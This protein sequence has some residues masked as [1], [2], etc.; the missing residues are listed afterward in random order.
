[1]EK[2]VGGRAADLKVEARGWSLQPAPGKHDG[3]S[4][5]HISM[6][7]KG[8]TGELIVR[9]SDGLVESRVR[10]PPP[11]AT[12]E[13]LQVRRRPLLSFFGHLYKKY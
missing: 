7:S 4:Q 12:V 13:R 10:L 9:G 5:R 3:S 8:K 11:A 2:A 6:S 1:M